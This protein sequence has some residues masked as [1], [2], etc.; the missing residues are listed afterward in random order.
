MEKKCQF[1]FSNIPLEAE[2]CRYCLEWVEEK[3][4]VEELETDKITTGSYPNPSYLKKPFQLTLIEKIP[5][6]PIVSILIFCV[7]IFASIQI[8]WFTLNENK[9]YLLSFLSF[10]IQ[11]MISWYGLIW[12]YKL[13]RDNYQSFI[14]IS[15]QPKKNSEEKFNKYQKII[16][17]K[18][19]IIVGI[20][21]GI[22]A[23]VG[24]YSVG[25]PFTTNTAKLIFAAFEFTNMFF[26]GAAI[27]SMFVFAFFMNN[28][29]KDSNQEI[30]NTN[31][32]SGVNNIGLIHLKTSILA[33]VPLFLGVIA[34]FFGSWK[35]EPLI[36]L[37]YASFA[38]IIIIYIYWP[39]LNIHKMM[40]SDK[41]NQVL[42]IQN[43][44]QRILNE[45]KTNP[46][47]RNFSRLYQLREL[48]K[49]ISNQ[50][51]WPFDT[52]SISAAFVAIIFPIILMLIDKIWSF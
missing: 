46:S 32:N 9:V 14:Q 51:T 18:F 23:A 27:Y 25:T 10:T 31:R 21:V 37:W 7:I 13:I 12:I 45:I 28:I 38:V 6:H 50:N 3:D 52:R 49:S 19:S 41:E 20:S 35:W 42:L 8:S 36:I 24:D 30:L 1:C 22:I 43:K 4:E 26:G 17:S 40:K 11:M 2:K 39:M 47:S 16:F 15:N 34:K 44:V 48:E 33:I 5:L 29:T